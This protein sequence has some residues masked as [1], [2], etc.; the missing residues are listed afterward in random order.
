MPPK[1]AKKLAAKRRGG[2]RKGSGR[3]PLGSRRKVRQNITVDGDAI[4]AAR[5]QGINI[6]AVC[7]EAIIKATNLT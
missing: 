4:N 3:K 2:A 6:S 1:K 5:K 7:E